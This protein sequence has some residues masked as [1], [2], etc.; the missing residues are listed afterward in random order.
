MKQR[1]AKRGYTQRR[2]T[3]GKIVPRAGAASVILGSRDR[4][5][6]DGTRAGRRKPLFTF[7]RFGETEWPVPRSRVAQSPNGRG[8]IAGPECTSFA[9]LRGVPV[10][11]TVIKLRAIRLRVK[12][13]TPRIPTVDGQ[14][15]SFAIIRPAFNGR[16]PG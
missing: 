12:R 5:T 10:P 2:K 13:C 11:N 8:L 1:R 16:K 3:S 15:G 6:S 4:A 14:F 9:F 7:W